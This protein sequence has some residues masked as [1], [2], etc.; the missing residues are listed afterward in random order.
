[1]QRKG[2]RKRPFGNNDLRPNQALR[3]RVRDKQMKRKAEDDIAKHK[4]SKAVCERE[5]RIAE[6]QLKAYWA[7][8]PLAN[9]T[10]AE[11]CRG[12]EPNPPGQL[13]TAEHKEQ[14]STGRKQ[15]LA[16]PRASIIEK[17]QAEA[18]RRKVDELPKM[19]ANSNNGKDQ[20][21]FNWGNKAGINSDDLKQSEFS[22]TGIQPSNNKG[23]GVDVVVHIALGLLLI[24]GRLS[25]LQT[26]S[27]QAK[28]R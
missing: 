2:Q 6:V 21:D 8:F 12:E 23:H 19:Q 17:E 14:R 11:R 3:E 18:K 13:K 27:R 4:P 10:D 28:P 26:S 7:C 24:R 22:R 20:G 15:L 5:E 1:M 16:S 25:P 9:S